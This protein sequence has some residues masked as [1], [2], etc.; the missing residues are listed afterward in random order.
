MSGDKGTFTLEFP[1]PAPRRQPQPCPLFLSSSG[2]PALVS[3]SGPTN[4][5]KCTYNTVLFDWEKNVKAAIDTF[6]IPGLTFSQQNSKCLTPSGSEEQIQCSNWRAI[7]RLLF[8]KYCVR[9]SYFQVAANGGC[10]NYNLNFFDPDSPM[11]NGCSKMVDASSVCFDWMLGITYKANVD[12]AMQSY[13]DKLL[14]NDTAC[15]NATSSEVF[16]AI[17]GSPTSIPIPARCWWLPCE[18]STQA[19]KFLIPETT[20]KGG[21]CP[22]EV[23]IDINNIFANDTDLGQVTI[24]EFSTCGNLSPDKFP[25]YEQ[26]WFWVIVLT[27]IVIIFGIIIFYTTGAS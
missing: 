17:E 22:K 3:Q 19:E 9:N 16:K 2:S 24:N 15:L 8:P 4:Q 5:L 7:N 13:T 21:N 11:P 12:Q 14:T 27:L 23:C 1:M 10:P 25:W 26:W 6:A 20:R 18:A